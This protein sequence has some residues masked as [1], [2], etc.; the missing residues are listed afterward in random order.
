[1]PGA[2]AWVLRFAQDDRDAPG[3]LLQAG[4]PVGRDRA[5]GEATWRGEAHLRAVVLGAH[6]HRRDAVPAL[7]EV[8]ERDLLGPDVVPAHPDQ[9]GAEPAGLDRRPGQ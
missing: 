8:G 5:A 1:M 6:G 3:R 2:A 4:G 9:V 7:A